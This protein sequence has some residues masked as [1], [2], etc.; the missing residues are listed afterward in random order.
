MGEEPSGSELMVGWMQTRIRIDFSILD[1]LRLLTTGR[2]RI[3]VTT[4]T[5][6]K[7]DTAVSRTDHFIAAPGER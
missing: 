7:V 2:L 4:Y 1:R 3:L 6:A 5:D